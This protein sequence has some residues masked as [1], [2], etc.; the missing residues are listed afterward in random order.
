MNT[1]NLTGNLLWCDQC[2]NFF[3]YDYI[4]NLSDDVFVCI[5]EVE[6]EGECA[7]V[8]LK[9]KALSA[10]ARE[11]SGH[12]FIFS[13]TPSRR[14]TFSCFVMFFGAFYLLYQNL[15]FT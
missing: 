12:P 7:R 8:N 2:I 9:K 1:F 3:K 15:I 14:H 6:D 13:D 4:P 11:L 10:A 5:A